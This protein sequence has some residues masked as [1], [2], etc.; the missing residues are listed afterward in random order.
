MFISLFEIAFSFFSVV[1]PLLLFPT[2]SSLNPSFFVFHFFEFVV[3][4]T[5]SR[6]GLCLLTGQSQVLGGIKL[7]KAWPK[8][9]VKL[10][11]MWPEWSYIQSYF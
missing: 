6:F 4:L 10:A 5:S 2:L 7:Q 11:Q 8:N 3:D 9:Q 1:L